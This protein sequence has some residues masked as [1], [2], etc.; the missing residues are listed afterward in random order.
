MQKRSRN[1]NDV[2][3]KMDKEIR[4]CV[5]EWMNE[6]MSEW[7]SK[8]ER[9]REPL[10]KKGVKQKASFSI[11]THSHLINTNKNK[12]LLFCHS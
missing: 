2:D 11:T 12:E 5:N 1:N 9:M 8:R 3:V 6:W 7:V 4:E 10:T